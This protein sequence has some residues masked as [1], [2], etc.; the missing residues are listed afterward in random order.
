VKSIITLVAPGTLD[1]VP[2]VLVVFPDPLPV[3][4]TLS[5]AVN[6]LEDVTVKVTVEAPDGLP[7][8]V[9]LVCFSASY[10]A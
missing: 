5:P 6:I 7:L 4:N 2:S 10:C 8:V 3:T 9:A 1:T